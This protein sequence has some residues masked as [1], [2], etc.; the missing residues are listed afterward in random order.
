MKVY[1]I[2]VSIEFEICGI[3]PQVLDSIIDEMDVSKS[4]SL[5]ELESK[6]KTS[7]S[8]RKMLIYEIGYQEMDENSHSL[9]NRAN[10]KIK[11]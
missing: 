6:L 8:E 9:I 5:A 2:D 1:N 7:I 11:C 4:L 3:P 10:I